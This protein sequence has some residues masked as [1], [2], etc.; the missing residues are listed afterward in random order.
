MDGFSLW[1]A[2]KSLSFNEIL[3]IFKSLL[4]DFIFLK[5]TKTVK[6]VKP[7][8]SVKQVKPVNTVK[9]VKPVNTVKQV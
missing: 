4:D 6:P 7:I 8:K 1:V 3:F 2:W 5:Q 9:Q